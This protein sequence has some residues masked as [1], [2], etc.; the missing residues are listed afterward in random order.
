[1]RW[2]GKQ[3][4]VLR[5]NSREVDV[6]GAV[7]SGKT[8]VCLWKELRAGL[9]H[10]G[11]HMLLSRWS[12]ETTFSQLKPA[13]DGICEAAEIDHSWNARESCY[14]WASGTRVYIKGLR[15]SQE[16]QKYSKFRGLTLARVYVDQAEEIEQDVY[17]ELAIRLSQSGFPHQITLSPQSVEE[18]HWITEE[19]PEDNGLPGRSYFPLATR[20]NEHN[21]PKGYVKELER[22]YPVDHPKHRTLVLGQRGMNVSGVP[23][24]SGAYV[25]ELHEK[26]C[27]YDAGL[28][29][30]VG[31]DFGKKHPCVIFRQVSELG[32]IRILGGIMGQD[33]YLQDFLPVVKRHLSAWYPDAKVKW[34]GDP[35]GSADTSQ[36]TKGAGHIMQREY[37]I[38]VRFSR[39]ANSPAARLGAIERMAGVMRKRLPTG[40]ESFV[41]NSDPKRWLRVSA[42]GAALRDRFLAGALEAGYVWDKHTISVAHKQVRRPKKDG[43]YEH[44]CNALEYLAITFDLRYR[45]A[46]ETVPP[47]SSYRGDASYTSNVEAGWMNA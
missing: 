8:T 20:D 36:G 44:G 10:P 11:I 28:P 40:D 14:D 2:R 25:R 19:F 4:Q 5:C 30:E 24:Y 34:A 26:P 47:L 15:A 32:Q 13:W 22:Q 3:A 35:A 37:G 31:I 7:R 6:E 46:V 38:K 12:D 1:M 39:H 45:E 17:K 16:E 33:L 27:K 23:V 29:L 18:G 41:V 9:K 42:R 21:L 43:W